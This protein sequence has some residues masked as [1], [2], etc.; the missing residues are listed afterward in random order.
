MFK[1]LDDSPY[2]FVYTG[3]AGIIVPD[4]ISEVVSHFRTF[5]RD[6]GT[7]FAKRL[8]IQIFVYLFISVRHQFISRVWRIHRYHQCKRLFL[9]FLSVDVF[10]SFACLVFRTPLVDIIEAVSWSS[11]I[12][13]HRF[14]M[15]II[16]SI[17]YP[18]VETVAT[19]GWTPFVPC[20]FPAIIV[21]VYIGLVGCIQMPLSDVS[22]IVSLI[23]KHITPTAGV[24]GKFHSVRSGFGVTVPGYFTANGIH[25]GH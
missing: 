25:T 20:H 13:V 18:M 3:D 21:S 8:Y 2:I 16:C 17:S 7:S 9:V 6:I 10:D 23:F 11:G 14:Q 19:F 12:P 15:V 1:G 4:V 5:G 24:L 22:H